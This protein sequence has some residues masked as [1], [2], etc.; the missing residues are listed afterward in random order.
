MAL[1]NFKFN[2]KSFST[3][4]RQSFVQALNS[5]NKLFQAIAAITEEDREPLD[6]TVLNEDEEELKCDF[7][8]VKNEVKKAAQGAIS[9]STF[10][11]YLNILLLILRLKS[12]N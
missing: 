5:A 10:K 8:V 2:R 7:E 12:I 6:E 3:T 1:C 9:K 4:R 11:Q